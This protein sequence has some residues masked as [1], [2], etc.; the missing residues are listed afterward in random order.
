MWAQKFLIAAVIASI[1]TAGGFA[2]AAYLKQLVLQE[3]RNSLREAKAAGTLP[4]EMQ[5]LDLDN[6]M[7]MDIGIELSSQAMTR[8]TIVD[9][10][11]GLWYIWVP[12]VFAVC[13]GI[14]ALL[15]R[16]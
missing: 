1:I 7:R 6:F 8:A 10:L 9:A 2:L 11:R 13:L 16:R 15:G 14:A 3:I 4:P 12:I 5:D